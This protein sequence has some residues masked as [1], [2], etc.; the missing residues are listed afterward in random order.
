MNKIVLDTQYDTEEVAHTED[1]PGNLEEA[2]YTDGELVAHALGYAHQCGDE[3]LHGDSLV[4]IHVRVNDTL[5][6]RG[7]DFFFARDW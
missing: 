5:S 7:Q 4:R 2:M 6:G 3:C 1:L